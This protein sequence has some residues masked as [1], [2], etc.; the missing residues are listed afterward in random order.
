RSI[1][2]DLNTENAIFQEMAAQGQSMFA[3]SGDRGAFDNYTNLST[4]D[5]ASQPYVTAVGGTTLS[6]MGADGPW[7]SETTWNDAYGA[8]GGGVSQVW[9]LPIYQHGIGSAATKTSTTNRNV[10]DVSLNS[11]PLSGYSVY[12]SGNPPY[13]W[14]LVGGTSAASPLWSAFAAIV[15]Q[16][17]AAASEPLMGFANHAIYSV[18]EGPN[19]LNDFHDIADNSNNGYFPARAGYDNATGWGTFNGSNLLADLIAYNPVG[20]PVNLISDPGFENGSNYAPWI[21]TTGVVNNSSL[22]AAHGGS[23]YAWLD[24]YG[25][26]HEDTL[27]QTV[28]IPAGISRALLT[29][30]L[31]V[32]TG[33]VV[34]SP[35]STLS[36][37][38]R[39][40]SGQILVPLAF[41]SNL[42]AGVGYHQQ[43]FDLTSFQG[44]TIQI[45]FKGD[46]LDPIPTDFVLD[47]F[48]LTAQ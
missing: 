31:H 33:E 43:T 13:L 5:P 12:F 2:A 10:P 35:I 24:G 37:Y 28:A 4:E 14:Y 25:T 1:P 36:L 29:F 8:G 45:Y 20:E 44:Q 30:W 21:A 17:R 9:P 18:A 23:W 46:Q 19:Y 26:K 48:T 11:S 38:I 27:Y 6:T 15:N 41:Y 32:D 39:N 47:D 22:E 3:S 16:G 40:S 42:N 7:L 34:R